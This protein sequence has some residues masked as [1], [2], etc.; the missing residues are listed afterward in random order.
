MLALAF[1]L[2]CQL[3]LQFAL[4]VI[5]LGILALV[6]NIA[7]ANPAFREKLIIGPA[8]SLSGAIAKDEKATATVRGLIAPSLR[9]GCDTE[10]SRVAYFAA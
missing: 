9:L 2:L 8:R 6:I 3:L 1:S 10:H 4:T 5:S 7:L